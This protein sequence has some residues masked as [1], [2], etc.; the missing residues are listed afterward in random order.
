MKKIVKT[1]LHL[2][3]VLS[4]ALFV[5]VGGVVVKLI[6]KQ[7]TNEN[8]LKKSPLPFGFGLGTNH[9][10]ADIPPPADGD[11]DGGDGDGDC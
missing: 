1:A 9:A 5:F 3:S 6:D 7:N 11:C 8:G 10:L 2:L 4:L